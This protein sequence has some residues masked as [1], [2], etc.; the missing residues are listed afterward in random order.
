MKKSQIRKKFIKL[1]ENKLKK[2]KSINYNNIIKLLKKKGIKGKI[3]G[4]YYPYNNEIDCIQI[5]KKLEKKNYIISLP[6]IKKNS[7]MD[8]IQWSYKDPLVINKFGIPEPSNGKIKFPDILLMPL[9]SFDTKLNRVGYGGGFYDRYI[10][11]IKRKKKPLLVGLAYSFQK[12]KSIPT[13]R[14][15]K[16]LDFVMTEKKI[17][18]WEYY[19]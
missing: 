14:Y 16:K 4:G 17:I 13:N 9:L 19:F 3:V 18:E 2:I 6:K 7:Q 1:R 15:D 12:V 8:F 5:L 11:R 10:Q